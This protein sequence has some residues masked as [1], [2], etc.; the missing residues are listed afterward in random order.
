M[1]RSRDLLFVTL[2]AA[3]LAFAVQPLLDTAAPAVEPTAIVIHQRAADGARLAP[4]GATVVVAREAEPEQ[5]TRRVEETPAL[6][7]AKPVRR[8]GCE[9]AISALAGREARQLLPSRCLA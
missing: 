1:L 7:A 3:L 6:P 8:V 5:A 4:T 9:G 2:P